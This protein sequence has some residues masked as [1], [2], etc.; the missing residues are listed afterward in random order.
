MDIPETIRESVHPLGG[1]INLELLF[2]SNTMVLVLRSLAR[3]PDDWVRILATYFANPMS[4]GN[5]TSLCS[6]SHLSAKW[7]LYEVSPEGTAM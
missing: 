3:E 5:L 6:A 2:M 4:L 7:G 1:V